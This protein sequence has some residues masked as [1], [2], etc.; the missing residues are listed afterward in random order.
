MQS[1]S[2]SKGR[3]GAYGYGNAILIAIACLRSLRIEFT[4][5]LRV[6]IINNTWNGKQE[7]Q[8]ESTIKLQWRPN[9]DNCEQIERKSGHGHVSMSWRAWMRN[10]H[11]GDDGTSGYEERKQTAKNWPYHTVAMWCRLFRYT[12]PKVE[13]V[14]SIARVKKWSR[15][16]GTVGENRT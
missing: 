7:I 8:W 12:L 15:R 2:V 6:I 14:N 5:T 11:S 4:T 16:V 10:W 13:G 9:W 3:W 1:A